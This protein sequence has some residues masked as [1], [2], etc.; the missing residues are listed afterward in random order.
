M[1]ESI[2]LSDLDMILEEHKNFTTLSGRVFILADVGRASGDMPIP[3][4]ALDRIADMFR[5]TGFFCE[6]H[7][8]RNMAGRKIVSFYW[9]L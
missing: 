7:F 5:S 8:E 2:D 9:E 6:Y 4:S 1:C 3:V